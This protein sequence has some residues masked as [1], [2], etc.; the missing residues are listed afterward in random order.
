VLVRLKPGILDAQGATVMR[1]LAGLGFG[2]VGEVR[3]GKVLD[4]TLSGVDPA[5]ARQRVE[6]MCSRLL[7][8]PVIEDCTVELDG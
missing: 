6:Q 5:Q 4:L 3:V 1:A 2:E 7:V 8:N